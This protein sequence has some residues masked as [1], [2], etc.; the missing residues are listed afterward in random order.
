MSTFFAKTWE[1]W[2]SCFRN[3]I[4]NDVEQCFVREHLHV[5][6]A[7][8]IRCMLTAEPVESMA[9]RALC[10]ENALSC[11]LDFRTGSRLFAVRTLAKNVALR[12]KTD[13]RQT[14][15]K[16]VSPSHV[17]LPEFRTSQGDSREK[18]TPIMSQRIPLRENIF[19]GIGDI[20]R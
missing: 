11:M 2:H 4:V 5:S 13:Q 1:P 20:R 12:A 3:S 17:A 16:N 18:D 9:N 7:D 8:N 15:L 14:K 6:S 19:L 10:L